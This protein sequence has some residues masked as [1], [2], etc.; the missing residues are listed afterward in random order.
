MSSSCDAAASASGGFWGRCREQS[1]RFGNGKEG[2]GVAP[3]SYKS[4]DVPRCTGT[5]HTC[6]EDGSTERHGRAGGDSPPATGMSQGWGCSHAFW[7]RTASSTPLAA[8]G[9]L[10]NDSSPRTPTA[11]SKAHFKTHLP[12]QDP[13]KHS[14]S[15]RTAWSP[16]RA[17]LLKTFGVN[18]NHPESLGGQQGKSTLDNKKGD[19]TQGH[20]SFERG[21]LEKVPAPGK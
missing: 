8:M 4:I 17:F 6:E 11:A 14:R 21:W 12:P 3:R 9:S 2:N 1:T 5:R 16:G 13:C 15:T 19:E 20:E 10:A 7:R 18:V